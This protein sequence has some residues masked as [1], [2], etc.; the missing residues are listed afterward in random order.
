ML[1]TYELWCN[2]GIGKSGNFCFCPIPSIPDPTQPYGFPTGTAGIPYNSHSHC[3][4]CKLVPFP[5]LIGSGREWEWELRVG[6]DTLP[7]TKMLCYLMTTLFQYGAGVTDGHLNDWD[8]ETLLLLLHWKLIYPHQPLMLC[9]CLCLKLWALSCVAC[10]LISDFW[11]FGCCFRPCHPIWASLWWLLDAQLPCYGLLSQKSYDF[12]LSQAP[13]SLHRKG[14]FLVILHAGL[15]VNCMVSL[16]LYSHLSTPPGSICLC[17]LA[18]FISQWWNYCILFNSVCLTCEVWRCNTQ[19]WLVQALDLGL[20]ALLLD[21]N[22]HIS[23]WDFQDER[24]S[25][26]YFCW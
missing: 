22:R 23:R 24:N 13:N 26:Y 2:Q 20:Q 6:N 12:F 9:C 11:V 1:Q 7:L 8:I 17:I 10:Q 3:G 5:T 14:N 15:A 18:M 16:P 4:K 25:P 21:G 19:M